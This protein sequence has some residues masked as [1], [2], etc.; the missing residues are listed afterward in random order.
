[1]HKKIQLDEDPQA[2]VLK[3][4]LRKLIDEYRTAIQPSTTA[5]SGF[6]GIDNY[7]YPTQIEVFWLKEPPLQTRIITHRSDRP[8]KEIIVNGPW[9]RDS[10]EEKTSKVLSDEK[11]NVSTGDPSF[12][13]FGELA[14][15]LIRGTIH[16]AEQSYFDSSL[17]PQPKVGP[18]G[19]KISFQNGFYEFAR[20]LLEEGYHERIQENIREIEKYLNFIPNSVEPIVGGSAIRFY[21][22]VIWPPLTFE[23]LKD[24]G[25]IVRGEEGFS[26]IDLDSLSL[27][28]IHSVTFAGTNV[29]CYEHGIIDITSNKRELASQI[30]NTITGIFLIKGFEV[31]EIR[32]QMIIEG[33]VDYLSTKGELEDIFS[34]LEPRPVPI[35][36]F[37]ELVDLASKAYTSVDSRNDLIQLAKSYTHLKDGLYSEAFVAAWKIIETHLERF[38]SSSFGIVPLPKKKDSKKELTNM[39]NKIKKLHET[40][41]LSSTDYK[42]IDNLRN[43]RNLELHGRK[44]VQERDTMACFGLAKRIVEDELVRLS[45]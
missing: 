14:A 17:V 15:K 19:A 9:E 20:D 33:G 42:I 41:A 4:N 35:K 11:W 30:L 32:D 40:G 29:S 6:T 26:C 45:P 7:S 28:P 3:E 24:Y 23:T 34:R 38:Y 37:K 36:W 25:K 1:M 18:G 21:R 22:S 31:V 39:K 10:F 27:E 8:D 13:T 16:V 43:V 12:G 2:N 44:P 5:Q